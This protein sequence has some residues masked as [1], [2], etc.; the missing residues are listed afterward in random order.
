MIFLN[1][2]ICV[3]VIDL[4]KKFL[5]ALF[6]FTII[7]SL[8]ACGKKANNNEELKLYKA[9]METFF[10]NIEKIDYTIKTID[11]DCDDNSSIDSLFEQLDLLEKEFKYLSEISVPDDFSYNES[12]A[13]EAYD[14]MV[15]A[16]DYY[17]QSFTE[18]S[19]NPY[20]LEAADECYKR[21]NK[22]V[23]Y[24]INILHGE[25]PQDENVSYQ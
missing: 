21:A 4:K 8:T 23:Q 11:P 17:H 24:I 22:R 14:Y 25:L 15:Q 2:F 1:R 18:S 20:T 9:S 12:L 16:N 6:L 5:T 10:S 3:E 19:F 7:F 13:D